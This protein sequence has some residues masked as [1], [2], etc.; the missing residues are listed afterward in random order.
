MCMEVVDEVVGGADLTEDERNGLSQA[1]EWAGRGFP[2]QRA[3]HIGCAILTLSG[4]LYG[5]AHIA[6]RRM[7]ASTCGERMALEAAQSSGDTD[8]QKVFVWGTR[9]D[10]VFERPVAPC[11][12]CR[13]LFSENATY[14]LVSN[15]LFILSNT[16]MSLIHRVHLSILYPYPF[17]AEGGRHL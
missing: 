9:I 12:S 17:D 6:R 14:S 10:R 1:R 13:Q 11:G 4:R 8:I 2:P 15:P 3:T 5:G 7:Y 16:E